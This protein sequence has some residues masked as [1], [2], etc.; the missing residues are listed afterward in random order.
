MVAVHGNVV[1]WVALE[2][3]YS[4]GERSKRRTS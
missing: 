4:V 1:G 3:A 2:K